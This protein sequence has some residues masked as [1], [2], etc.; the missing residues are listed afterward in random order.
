MHGQTVTLTCMPTVCHVVFAC[1][2]GDFHLELLD[3]LKSNYKKN[4]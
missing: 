4:E 1:S 2:L 3:M